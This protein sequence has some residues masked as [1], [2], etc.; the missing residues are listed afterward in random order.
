MNKNLS[1]LYL[2]F[3][4]SFCLA[5]NFQSEGGWVPTKQTEECVNNTHT[6]MMSLCIC[7]RKD[8]AYLEKI[9]SHKLK[10]IGSTQ[11]RAKWSKLKKGVEL[12]CRRELAKGIGEEKLDDDDLNAP[13]YLASMYG[14][15]GDKYSDF[16]RHFLNTRRG[17][18]EK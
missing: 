4:F 6:N 2:L 1:I 14:C 17:F 13:D 8:N 9:I 10:K 12:Q 3:V 16:N 18:H 11:D 7:I 5:K 15:I